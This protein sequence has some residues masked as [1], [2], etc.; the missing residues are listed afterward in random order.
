MQSPSPA[1]PRPAA[2]PRPLCTLIVGASGG[3]G[4]ALVRQYAATGWKVHA[5]LRKPPADPVQAG[6]PR[7]VHLHPLDLRDRAQTAALGAALAGLPLDLL[8]VA[9]GTYDRVGGAFGSGPPVPPDEVFDINAEAPMRVAE[10][11]F[12]NLRAAAPSRMVFLSSAEGIRTGGRQQGVYGQSKARLNDHVREYA[13][14][15]AYF[16]V[17]GIALHPGWVRTGMG[18][19]RAPLTPDQSAAGIQKVVAGLTPDHCGA[20]LDYRGNMLPW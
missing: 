16:G 10:A 1:A 19:A 13:G 20:F 2:A 14:E 4:A 15:W 8:I 17:I 5:T 7:G 3:I 11:V 9:A 12:A 6:L 18:G